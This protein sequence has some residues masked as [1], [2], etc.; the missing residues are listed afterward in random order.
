MNKTNG[1]TFVGQLAMW[2]SVIGAVNWGLVG[3]ADFDLVRA[4]LG[5]ETSTPASGLSRIVYALVGVAGLALAL[6]APRLRARS[7]HTGAA[8]GARVTV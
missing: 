1:T 2:L 4:I 3:V 7:E 6:V 5:G 8:H